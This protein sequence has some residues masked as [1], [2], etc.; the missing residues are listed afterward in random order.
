MS[1]EELDVLELLIR[2]ELAIKRLYEACAVAFPER[3]D[4][5][6]GI[7]GDEQRHSDTLEALRSGDSAD[8]GS[9]FGNRLK[10]Q[11]IKSSIAY[12]E[13]QTARAEGGY[14]SLREALSVARDLETALLE[15]QFSRMSGSAAAKV[16]L[17]L[18]AD[19]EGHRRAFASALEAEKRRM[20]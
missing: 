1:E 16:L 5:W 20:P 4:L 13:K 6:Q 11:A 8:K 19:T 7:A 12:V 15:K 10:P 3:R 2:H 17:G 9:W 14:L 18:A